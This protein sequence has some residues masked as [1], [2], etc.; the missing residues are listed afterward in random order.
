MSAKPLASSSLLLALGASAVLGSA[1]WASPAQ[2]DADWP[3]WQA[4]LG[5]AT[6]DASASPSQGA[7][8][9]ASSV[10]S[11]SLLGDWYFR[12]PGLDRWQQF[13]GFRAT[14]GLIIGPRFALTSA[15]A[16][17][18]R[19][20]AFALGHQ[21]LIGVDAGHAQSTGLPYLGLGF[22]SAATVRSGLSFQA[23]V[24]VLMQNP[25]QQLPRLG[26]ALVSQARVD[27]VLR[28]LRWSP[29]LTLGIRYSF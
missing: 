3:R 14:S 4:R 8:L 23:D 6:A 27:E 24:G 12:V 26:R 5:V 29:L 17:P 15:L 1:A 19:G 10:Q 22:S 16:M 11:A 7:K 18:S 9:G 25:Q 13:G 2:A 28:E 21:Q 20:S